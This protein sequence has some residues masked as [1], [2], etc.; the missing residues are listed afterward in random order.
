VIPAQFQRAISPEALAQISSQLM[1][2][3]P[4][5]LRKRPAL[6]MWQRFEYP[7]RFWA[8]SSIAVPEAAGARV[9]WEPMISFNP[10]FLAS[11]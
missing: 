1:L 7:M 11:K 10:S 8:R 3:L 9:I 6:M 5:G 2:Q 4:L